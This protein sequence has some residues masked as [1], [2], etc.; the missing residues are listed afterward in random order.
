MTMKKKGGIR[1]E[2][3]DEEDMKNSRRW[4]RGDGVDAEE[5][6]ERRKRRKGE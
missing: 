1:G 4:E 6:W 5:E 2:G 3:K